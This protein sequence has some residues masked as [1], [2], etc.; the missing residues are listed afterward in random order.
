M[1]IGTAEYVCTENVL[2]S[3]SMWLL[4]RGVECTADDRF[5]LDGSRLALPA[6]VG[7]IPVLPTGASP[8]QSG[9]WSFG[10][11]DVA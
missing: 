6:Q 5:P 11:Q 9:H 3:R 1:Y 2:P 10:P 8:A 7:A 4:A